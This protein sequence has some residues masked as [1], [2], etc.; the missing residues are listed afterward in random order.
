MYGERDHRQQDDRAAE[1]DALSTA[2]YINGVEFAR[3]YCADH[4]RVG[5]ILLPDGADRPEVIGLAQDE[6][7]LSC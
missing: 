7:S 3:R 4:P 5:A 2:F 6:F 1:A